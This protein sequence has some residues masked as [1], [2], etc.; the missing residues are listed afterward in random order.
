MTC[1]VEVSQLLHVAWLDDL[2]RTFLGRAL[3]GT[4]FS[5]WDFPAYPIGAWL[6]WVIARWIAETYGGSP[7]KASQ[8][9][10]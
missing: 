4:S 2:R 3:L 1:I 6:G 7:C 10:Q 8:R 9:S 5:W